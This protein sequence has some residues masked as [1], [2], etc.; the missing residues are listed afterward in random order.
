M[1]KMNK[2]EIGRMEARLH[3]IAA[4]SRGMMTIEQKE[5]A[6]EDMALY[7]LAINDRIKILEYLVGYVT[8]DIRLDI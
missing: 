2:E 1:I 6:M 8:R 7:L 5:L 4:Q 3:S